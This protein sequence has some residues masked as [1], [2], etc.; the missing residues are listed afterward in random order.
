M[1]SV[2]KGEKYEGYYLLG[3]F[4]IGGNS[5]IFSGNISHGEVG[6]EIDN[7]LERSFKN[8][9][10]LDSPLQDQCLQQIAPRCENNLKLLVINK[11]LNPEPCY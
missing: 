5:T 4:L 6:C 10:V 3:V 1:S 7:N 2:K 8:V 9:L 11:L